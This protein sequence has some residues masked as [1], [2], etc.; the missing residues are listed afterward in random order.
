MEQCQWCETCG[1]VGQELT[2]DGWLLA[3]RAGNAWHLRP[4]RGGQ[5]GPAWRLSIEAAPEDW[6]AYAAV[7]SRVLLVGAH[8]DE[9][10]ALDAL[11]EASVSYTHLDVYKRQGRAWVVCRLVE[12]GGRA[13]SWEA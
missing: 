12:F 2:Y 1:G 6:A 8:P 7:A 5:G 9:D 3:I 4:Y 13:L 10:G 11:I